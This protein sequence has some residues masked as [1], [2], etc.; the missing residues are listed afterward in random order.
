M[1]AHSRRVIVVIPFY[2]E[3]NMG[4][5]IQIDFSS[6]DENELGEKHWTP[7]SH[8]YF[9]S[10]GYNETKLAIVNYLNIGDVGDPEWRDARRLPFGDEALEAFYPG[11]RGISFIQYPWEHPDADDVDENP[12]TRMISSDPTLEW[13]LKEMEKHY[14]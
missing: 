8:N 13:A 11:S 2:M 14:G 1:A 7:P 5:Q 12:V 4:K 3:T 10:H 9:G 6:F